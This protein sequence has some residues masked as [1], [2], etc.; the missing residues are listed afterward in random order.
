MGGSNL[1]ELCSKGEVEPIYSYLRQIAPDTIEWSD[2]KNS[3][4]EDDVI[5][6]ANGVWGF[7]DGDGRT[8][9]HWSIAL[10]NYG[11]AN[12]LMNEPYR[13]PVLSEDEDGVT[14]FM[15]AC[16]VG[17]PEKFVSLLLEKSVLVYHL[18]QKCP[19][20]QRQQSVEGGK[21]ENDSGHKAVGNLG[22]TEVNPEQGVVLTNDAPNVSNEVSISHEPVATYKI[23]NVED[24]MGNTSLLHVASRGHTHLIDFLI[25][26]GADLNHQN[27]RGQ[28]ALHRSVGRGD[29]ETVEKLLCASKQKIN[30]SKETHRRWMNLQD[31][32]G[33]SVLFYASMENNEDLG[34]LL[35]QNGANRDLR[36]KE[37][38]EFWEV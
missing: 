32:R 27:R 3:K 28:S 30:R 18:F 21:A 35:L 38:K 13:S 11:L 23:V 6:Y 1:S 12:T 33:D 26:N 15:T 24:S 8:A 7:R 14:P 25:K 4:S 22:D 2:N 17:A 37:G 16:M 10:R 34:R 20:L 9:F 29:M 31:Y 5:K 36:N 19:L